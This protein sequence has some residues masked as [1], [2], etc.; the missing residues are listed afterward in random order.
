MSREQEC[1]AELF[2]FV[3]IITDR[4]VKR[5]L[6]LFRCAGAGGCDAYQGMPPICRKRDDILQ[7]YED[8][9]YEAIKSKN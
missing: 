5:D 7:R 1:I 9:I 3:D 8:I 6:S 2:M 4:A